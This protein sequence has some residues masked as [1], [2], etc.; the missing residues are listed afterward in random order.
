MFHSLNS[1]GA[2]N[3]SITIRTF[4]LKAAVTKK[5][6]VQLPKKVL[7]KKR[8]MKREEKKRHTVFPILGSL[9]PTGIISCMPVCTNGKTIGT[10]SASRIILLPLYTSSTV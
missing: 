7:K 6:T 5:H 10:L 2:Q 3:N 1:L 9:A 4:V 8:K